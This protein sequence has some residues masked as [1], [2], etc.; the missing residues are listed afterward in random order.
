MV[1]Q[2][3]VFVKT[4]YISELQQ[5]DELK[6]EPFL[7]QDLVR[8]TT[9]DG[10]PYLL[11]TLGDKTGQVS[12]VFWDLPDDVDGWIR[13][14][15]VI[16][17]SGR[18]AHYKDSLQVNA[19]DMNPY[20][21][22][23]MRE[24]L[25]SSSRSQNEMIDELRRQVRAL[26]K[27]WQDLA[28]AVLLDESFLQRFATAPA[29][30]TMHHAFIGGLMEHTLS[31]ATLARYLASH[32]PYVNE[33]LLVTGALLHDVGKAI[34]YTTEP[35]FAFSDDGRLVGHI[36]RAV[37]IV[38]KAADRVAGISTEQMRQLVHLIVSHHGTNEWGSPVV[39]KTIEAVLLHQIDLLDSRVQG[40]FDHLRSE[41]SDGQWSTRPSYMF[42][43]ELRRPPGFSNHSH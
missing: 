20:L 25:P 33:D 15:L 21:E 2:R 26:G 5:G 32:Y 31:M 39:P 9:K 27:P 24:F 35:A 30:R 36:V 43:T 6:N 40:F 38:E 17:V 34:E 12:S 1:G 11:C 13:P 3:Q 28:A 19:T 18:V 22:P 23:D 16:L 10:R 37:V 7:L 29:A 42:S 41:T 8:R 4:V 14:G